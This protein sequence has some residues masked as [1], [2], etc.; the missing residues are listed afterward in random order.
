[1]RV[2]INLSFSNRV[3]L[4]YGDAGTDKTFLA[5]A[6]LEQNIISEYFDYH[7]LREEKRAVLKEFISH[8]EG[9]FIIIDNTDII[10]DDE[11]R[12]MIYKDRKNQFLII[13]RDPRG[14]FLSKRNFVDIKKEGST[15][16]F[17]SKF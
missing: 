10:L 1:M 15:I 7:Y 2:N 14:L 9:F 12:N 6:I 11:L 16:S 17:Q 8:K 13:G 4:L 5:K 3:T